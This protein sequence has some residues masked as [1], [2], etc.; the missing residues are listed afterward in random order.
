MNDQVFNGIKAELISAVLTYP[1]NTLKTNSQVGKIVRPGFKNLTKGLHWCLLTELANALVF[2][3]VFENIKES[4]GPLIAS[5]IGSSAAICTS[6][7][8]NVRRKLAQVGKSMVI[9]N[10]YFGLHIALFNGVPGVTINY[11]LREK[12]MNKCENPKLKP[13]C[14][15]LSSAIS[16]VATHPLDTIST[17]IATRSPFKWCYIFNGFKHRF[18]EK[19]LTIGSKMLLLGHLNK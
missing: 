1:L 9:K 7:P 4:K 19:N 18:I 12:F 6:Y 3:S 8:L 2:Y 10:N 16:I 5:V 17:C 11:T 15:V 13:F 14:G